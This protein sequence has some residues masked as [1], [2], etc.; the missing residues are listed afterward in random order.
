MLAD[1]YKNHVL[2]NLTFALVLVMGLLTYLQMPREQ[3]PTINF[4]WIQITT[5]FPG[6]SAQEVEKRITQPLEDALQTLS[7]IRFVSSTSRDSVSSILVRFNDISQETFSQRTIDLRREIQNKERELP[8]EVDSP[9][10][11]EITS[12]NAF[13]SA[14]VAVIG[15]SDDH[16]LRIHARSVKK[17]LERF[18]GV[19]RVDDLGLLEPELQILF[20]PQSLSLYGLTATDLANTVS[21]H[22]KDVSAG[23]LDIDENRWVIR[24]LG[25]NASPEYL[26]TLPILTAQG[27]LPLGKVAKVQSGRE[28]PTRLVHYNAQN[29]VIFSVMKQANTNILELVDEINHYLTLK[30]QSLAHTGIE[31]RLLDDQTQI[32]KDA[33]NIMQT[34]A[35]LGLIFVL[36]STWLFLGLRIAFLVS[37]GIPFTLCATFW[38]LGY[39]NITLNVS[40]LLGIV[41]SL[42]MLVDDAV[43][44][45][46]AIYY[47]IIRQEPKMQAILNALREVFK[48]VTTSILTTMAAFLPLMLLPGILGQFMLVIPLVVTSALLLSLIEAYWML[49]AHIYSS[50]IQVAQPSKIQILRNQWTHKVR[51]QYTKLLIKV[52]RYPVRVFCLLALLI[53]LSFSALGLGWIKFNFFAS[54]PLRI[55]YVNVE[56]PAGTPI[57]S[58]LNLTEKVEM[59]IRNHL[60]KGEARSV[61]SYAGLMFTEMAPF[62]GEQYGQILISLRPQGK[63]MRTVDEIID[64]M[65][66]S[67][68]ATA[69]AKVS[70]LRLA[71]GPPSS[72]PINIKVR[73]EDFDSIR[74][75]V[76]A[77]KT[78]LEKIPS[79]SDISDN[80]TVGQPELILTPNFD[81]IQRSGLDPSEISRWIKLMVD[82]EIV[83]QFQ[84]AGEELSVRV[85]ADL[86]PL[87]S[88]DNVLNQSIAIP[89]KGEIRLR[90]L[91][92]TQVKKGQSSILH[93][94]FKKTITITADI[95]KTVLDTVQANQLAKEYWQTIGH[96]HPNIDLEFSGELDDIEE[97]IAA[98]PKLLLM[99]LG[100]IY[101]ILGTQF[102]SYFQPLM[103]LCTVPIAFSG[104]IIGLWVTQ[105]PMSLFTMYGVVALA[106]ISVNSAIVLISAANDR[107]SRGMTVIH[108]TL[109][110]ARRRVIP[111]LITSLTTIA[112]LF[113]LATGLGGKSLL[114]GPVA[115]AIVWGLVVSTCLTLMIIPLLYILCMQKSTL[116]RLKFNP[117]FLIRKN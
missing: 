38:W 67:V 20:D 103:I 59:K 19:D 104:V 81:A 84:H 73:G 92:H 100:I 101:L 112:G 115:T 116:H 23:A 98:L 29:S 45:V 65:R 49:P 35:L 63:H 15:Q 74:H 93:Y 16:Q 22:F 3:D 62:L 44:V 108:S 91:V 9:D 71:G 79:I 39:L 80:D 36:L 50:S 27:E 24:W 6:A 64:S 28:K 11:F 34:N 2:A 10:I 95:D 105:N 43:V 53:T 55:F 18:K 77:Y 40:V 113:S 99:G 66:E 57:E 110:A 85:R 42:G 58:T 75:A 21:A 8:E 72:K 78:E 14:T 13:P 1:I 86:G 12:S 107:V 76:K 52:L 69:G 4:N 33:L 46:E 82:G 89:P 54:D 47:R 114:W 61:A 109:Y 94:N 87:H 7:D 102:K 51:I 56:L 60:Q 32:T 70:F 88:L 90:D 117:L 30:N 83:T 5:L 26:A 106:G 96:Q 17:D 31:V 48:P 25:T 68:I 97:S 111:I 41:I 37:I